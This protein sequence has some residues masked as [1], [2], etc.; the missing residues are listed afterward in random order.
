MTRALLVLGWLSATALACGGRSEPASSPSAP[1]E[2]SSA[3]AS[4]SASAER[5]EAA[6]PAEAAPAEPAKPRKPF[7]IYNGC[8]DVVTV[9]FGEESKGPDAGKR[10]IAPRS[11][12][13]APRDAQGNQTVSLLDASGEALIK[14]NVTRGMKRVEIGRSCRTLDA[15]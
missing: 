3:S 7:E 1:S 14:V 13:E 11:A 8:A 5:P 2:A 12:I 6:A 15:R 4:A 10:T 9:A